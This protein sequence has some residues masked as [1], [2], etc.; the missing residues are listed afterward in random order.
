MFMC[1]GKTQLLESKNLVEILMCETNG[2]SLWIRTWG[3]VAP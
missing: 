2:G 1:H 3:E